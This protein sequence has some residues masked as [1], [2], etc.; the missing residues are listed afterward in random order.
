MGR[1]GSSRGSDV[2]HCWSATKQEPT[3]L[4]EPH[5]AVPRGGVSK[6][7]RAPVPELPTP[8]PELVP[9]VCGAG[10]RVSQP[11]GARVRGW[12]WVLEL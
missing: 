9:A 11:H 6:A 12:Q 3:G 1:C 5:R 2:I 4:L 7:Q 8:M 10:T